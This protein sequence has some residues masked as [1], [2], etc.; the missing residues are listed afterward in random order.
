MCVAF[1]IHVLRF[2]HTHTADAQHDTMRCFT[3]IPHL[4][5]RLTNK[6]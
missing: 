5:I 3:Q 1:H 6:E 2:T 4:G